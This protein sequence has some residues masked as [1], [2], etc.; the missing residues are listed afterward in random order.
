[1]TANILV[2]E[3]GTHTVSATAMLEVAH[4]LEPKYI[5]HIEPDM[6]GTISDDTL[7]INH[8]RELAGTTWAEDFSHFE[9]EWLGK[10]PSVYPISIEING[11]LF[12]DLPISWGSYGA[13]TL[14]SVDRIGVAIVNYGRGAAWCEVNVSTEMFPDGVT[15]AKVYKTAPLRI[16]NDALPESAEWVTQHTENDFVTTRNSAYVRNNEA[17]QVIDITGHYDDKFATLTHDAAMLQTLIGYSYYDVVGKNTISC[18]ENGTVKERD[19]LLPDGTTATE[20]DWPL[21]CTLVGT[22]RTHNLYLLNPRPQSDR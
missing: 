19:V 9:S 22:D 14:G 3:P 15:S 12:R 21:G 17:T 10:N 5:G 1:M 7:I 13:F 18:V 8:M 2:T 4:T 11:R 20:N 6:I 16:P